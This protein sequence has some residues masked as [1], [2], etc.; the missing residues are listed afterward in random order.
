MQSNRKRIAVKFQGLARAFGGMGRRVPARSVEDVALDYHEAAQRAGILL[1]EAYRTGLLPKVPGLARLL[2]RGLDG[3]RLF[4][5]FH[6]YEVSAAVLLSG[7]LEPSPGDAALTCGLLPQL[8]PDHPVFRP[9]SY[10]GK[11]PDKQALLTELRRAREAC[12]WLAARIGGQGGDESP[13]SRGRSAG[14]ATTKDL[15]DFANTRR[16]RKTK[17][18]WK[19]ITS[20]WLVK[21][22]EA[23]VVDGAPLTWRH[24]CNA[25]R[26]CYGEKS[27][28]RAKRPRARSRK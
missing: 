6:G 23:T 13:V 5:Q 11:N 15:A 19:D 16:K 24:F 2:D 4:K 21:H 17:M 12:K 28:K 14:K 22:P 18:A 7:C 9:Q 8:L 27:S 25:W 1:V 10:R 26:T 3:A 20:E